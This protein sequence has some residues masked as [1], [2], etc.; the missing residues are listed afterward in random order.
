MN[1]KNA[2]EAKKYLKRERKEMRLFQKCKGL[3]QKL[4][5]HFV[6]KYKDDFEMNVTWMKEYYYEVNHGDILNTYVDYSV[7]LKKCLKDLKYK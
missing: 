3:E 1:F 5:E 2:K 4:G 6:G 7:Y